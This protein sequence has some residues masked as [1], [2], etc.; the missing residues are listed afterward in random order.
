M[1]K[2]FEYLDGIE[3][4]IQRLHLQATEEHVDSVKAIINTARILK[5]EF[6]AMQ[7]KI[8]DMSQEL[9]SI[10]HGTSQNDEQEVHVDISEDDE[11]G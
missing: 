4:C 8:N 7:Q 10:R 5:K 1:E 3:N 9:E 11:N 2:I 6:L